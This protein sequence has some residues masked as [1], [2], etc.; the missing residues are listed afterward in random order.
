M[1]EAVRC[2]FAAHGRFVKKRERFLLV[3]AR[4]RLNSCEKCIFLRQQ[5]HFTCSAKSV[6][7]W[8]GGTRSLHSTPHSTVRVQHTVKM[9]N[10]GESAL[11]P[12]ARITPYSGELASASFSYLVHSV[13]HW[14]LFDRCR[15]VPSQWVLWA[16]K[17]VEMATKALREP[18]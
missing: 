15:Q 13:L 2:I 6:N 14:L 16:K 5:R 4:V 9:A 1:S 7:A 3:S 11:P 17:S 8:N 10:Q 18:L 12:P